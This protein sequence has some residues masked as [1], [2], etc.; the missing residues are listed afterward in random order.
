MARAGLQV[1]DSSMISFL[2]AVRNEERHIGET[3][4]CLANQTTAGDIEIL[5]FD[6]ESSDHT[7]KIA[8]EYAPHFKHFQIH[9]NPEL[10]A[11]SAWNKG[12]ELARFDRV[13]LLSGHVLLPNTYCEIALKNLS[14]TVTGVGFRAIGVESAPSNATIAAACNSVMVTGGSAYTSAENSKAVDT[15]AYGTYWK[16]R[17]L[18]V[19]GFDEGIDRGQD[20]DINLRLTQQGQK[21]MLL[22]GDPVHYFV[23]GS[24]PQIYQRFWLAGLW[25]PRIQLKNRSLPKLRHLAPATAVIVAVA[26]LLSLAF[27]DAERLLPYAAA[28][29]ALYLGAILASYLQ[30]SPKPHLP[31]YLAAVIGIHFFYGAGALVGLAFINRPSS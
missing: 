26:L 18:S 7:I 25:K 5:I 17:I 23:R 10:S 4:E 22:S 20:W 31:T 11:S 13:A 6:A 1:I 29:S 16:D 2:I 28:M 12:V 3:L 27:L 19:G 8:Q 30:C 9:P 14:E 21:L 24:L 15:I